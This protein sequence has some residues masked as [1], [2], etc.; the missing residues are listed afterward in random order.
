M[1]LGIVLKRAN[2]AET[3]DA[4]SLNGFAAHIQMQSNHEN[5]Q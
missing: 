5:D 1:P 3:H 4:T 2:N